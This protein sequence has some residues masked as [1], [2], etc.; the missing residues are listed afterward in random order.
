M[1]NLIALFGILIAASAPLWAAEAVT[2]SA[3]DPYVMKIYPDGTKVIV[4]WSEIGK[5]VDNGEKFGGAPRIVAYDP[6]KDGVVPIGTPQSSD[7]KPT[8][9]AN[10]VPGSTSVVTPDQPA[11]M[12]YSNANPDDW[13][14]KQGGTGFYIGPEIG[15]A[16][17]S[18][19]NAK[20]ISG[21]VDLPFGY[22]ATG[23]VQSSLSVNPG[24][25]FNLPMGY[26]PVEW[27]EVEFAPGIIWNSLNT[28]TLGYQGSLLDP[29]NAPVAGDSGSFAIQTQGSY[30]QVPLVV[31]LIFRIPTGSPWVPYLGGGLGA[32]FN[33]MNITNYKYAP[34]GL[35]ENISSTDGSCWSFAYQAIGGFDYE[36][37]ENVSIGA[38]YVFTGTG[39]QNFG[40]DLEGL[41]IKNSISQSALLNCTIK[42]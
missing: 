35:N 20:T 27:F 40:G 28:L 13:D 36:I 16:F 30:Y 23:S 12:D 17:N 14:K 11:K 33:Y 1:K 5:A 2:K 6:A 32:S 25:R 21:S 9:A 31:N 37:N 41:S 34:A 29:D 7:T 19:L 22:E 26:R 39:N 38:K 4:R 10:A 18:N 3:N 24:I 8:S 15:A 42:F